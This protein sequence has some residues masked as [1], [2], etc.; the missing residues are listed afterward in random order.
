MLSVSVFL[1]VGRSCILNGNCFEQQVMAT[2]AEAVLGL[3]LPRQSRM[4]RRLL[5]LS[6]F[7]ASLHVR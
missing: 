7:V 1:S 3:P 6:T 4:A 2:R 5:H